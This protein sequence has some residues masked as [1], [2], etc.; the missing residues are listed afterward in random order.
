M[1]SP[2]RVRTI[3][4][5]IASPNRLDILRILNT[6]GPLSYSELKTLAGFKSKKESGKFAYHLRKLVKQTLI[7]LN[8][9]ERKYTATSL[10]RLVLNLTKQI[11]EQSMLES[12]KLYV[13]SSRQAMEEF[14]ADKILQSLVREAGMPVELAQKIASETEARVYKFQTAYLTAPLI[15]E[16]VNS[17]LV[18]HGYEE[19]RH[20]LTRLG[21]PV[22]DVAEL[23]ARAGDGNDSIDEVFATTSSRVFSEYSILTKIPR[24]V[25]DAHLSGDIHISGLGTWTLM[26]DTLYFD[27]N[28][29]YSNPYN[30]GSK[31]VSVPRLSQIKGFEAA[32]ETLVVLASITSREV[33]NEVCLDNLIPYLC[34]LYAPRSQEEQVRMFTKLF[35][36]LSAASGQGRARSISFR[37]GEPQKDEDISAQLELRDSLLDAYSA[38]AAS[39]P[40]PTVHLVVSPGRYFDRRVVERISRVV[41]EGGEIALESEG[42]YAFSGLKIGSFSPSGISADGMAV[43][44]NLTLNLPRLAYESNK[45]ETYFRAK[46][47]IL[48]QTAINALANRKDHVRDS[49]KKGLLPAL[50]QLPSVSSIDD[51]PIVV[52]MVGMN[53]AISNLIGDRE[54]LTRKEIALKILDTA[55]KVASEKGAKLGHRAFVSLIHEEGFQRLAE[56]DTDKYG[57]AQEYRRSGYQEGLIVQSEHSENDALISETRDLCR[58]ANGGCLVGFG[59][60]KDTPESVNYGNYVNSVSGK[61]QFARFSRNP[62]I[63]KKCGLKVFN[64]GRCP[65]C[66]STSLIAQPLL[67]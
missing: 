39:V 47:A 45:D 25:S 18:E 42:K 19:Y 51:L 30:L 5:V 62:E 55:S 8:R 44:H 6:K 4:S 46:L 15:R 21:L 12:G 40:V 66:K 52:N 57:R 2:R 32:M 63:C 1:S 56:I 14:N 37:V 27:L 50:S 33:S 28:A 43:L 41:A 35:W 53:E 58:A 20:K 11:E 23:I 49:L 64:G 26:P 16:I 31:L 34:K 48:L 61:L 67:V 29:L 24:D 9:A 54:S 10:G 17:L 22:A 65:N 36:S 59:F 60:P 13:R 7:S 38:F 3:Y